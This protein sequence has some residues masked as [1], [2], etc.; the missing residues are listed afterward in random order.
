LA[1]EN[2][3]V[4]QK[5][6]RKKRRETGKLGR[7]RAEW[8]KQGVL[9]IRLLGLEVLC[10]KSGCTEG[11]TC[12][13]N[14]KIRQKIL[15]LDA[16]RMVRTDKRRF[17][18]PTKGKNKIKR[19]SKGTTRK[20][21]QWHKKREHGI[22]NGKAADREESKRKGKG[23]G[24]ARPTKGI[25]GTNRV[26]GENKILREKIQEDR[27]KGKTHTVRKRRKCRQWQVHYTHQE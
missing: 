25:G 13:S 22:G 11:V 19:G 12:L 20:N 18:R 23:A 1:G 6:A 4:R 26:Q 8:Y 16:Y 14:V 7:S 10:P 3:G 21:A 24:G 5:E 17:M 15:P 9:P 2:G 27:A